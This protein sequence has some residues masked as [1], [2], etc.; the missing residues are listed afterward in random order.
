MRSSTKKTFPFRTLVAASMLASAL[1]TAS[2][3]AAEPKSIDPRLLLASRAIE[4]LDVIEATKLMASVP[5]EGEALIVHALLALYTGDCDR[6]VALIEKAGSGNE[7]AVQYFGPVAR[8]CAMVT[9]STVT[10]TDEAAGVSI[11]L[12]DDDD[13]PLVPY[14][15]EVL[16]KA[17]PALERDLGVTMP[18]PIRIE[19]VRDHHSLAA[20]TGLTLE[21]AQNTGTLAVAKWGRVTMLSPRAIPYGYAWADTLM[22]ELTHLAVTRASADEAPL[23]LQEGVAKRQEVRWREPFLYDGTPSPDAIAVAGFKKNLGLPLDK[24]GPSIAMLPTAEQAGV[25]FAEV[26]S[27]VRFWTKEAGDGALPKLLTTLDSP[28]HPVTVDAALQ[29]VSGA[30]LAGWDTKWR[31]Y[32]ASAAPPLPTDT[33]LSPP[34]PRRK[35]LSR[36]SR[37]GDLLAQRGHHQAAVSE[38]SRAVAASP[39]DPSG[40][41]RLALSLQAMGESERAAKEVERLDAVHGAHAVYLTLHADGLRKKGDEAN[42]KIASDQALWNGAFEPEVAC[43]NADSSGFPADPNAHALCAAARAVA[44]DR[45][46]RSPQR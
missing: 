22:H 15:I 30:D 45:G 39:H 24:L 21:A 16:A 17:L 14:L 32:L 6:A 4:K 37:L 40:H 31:A 38:L 7:Q 41:A 20:I 34:D 43:A 44:A 27:F 10:I 18:R 29:D 3:S 11:R 5:E 36:R 25:A 28:A 33:F 12:K 8:G 46:Q 35:E 13:A 23:W 1:S 9:A 19:L 2:T 42:A 26:T